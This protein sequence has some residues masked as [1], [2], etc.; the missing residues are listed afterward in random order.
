MP[1]TMLLCTFCYFLFNCFQEASEIF[2]FHLFYKETNNNSH[3][4]QLV[5]FYLIKTQKR[6]AR[7]KK[8]FL[9]CEIKERHKSNIYNY[10]KTGKE[11]LLVIRPALIKA[12]GE[13]NKMCIFWR[14][15]L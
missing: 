8:A 6:L 11:S 14:M 2:V 15:I 5:N 7:Q 3:P 9:E 1:T 12:N 13:S 4:I 10:M